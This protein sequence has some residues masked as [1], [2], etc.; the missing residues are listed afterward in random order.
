MHSTWLIDSS[1]ERYYTVEPR[2]RDTPDFEKTRFKRLIA[3]EQNQDPRLKDFWS[4]TE[5]SSL[6]NRSSTVLV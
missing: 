1:I 3:V 4:V 2:F 6:L 5:E